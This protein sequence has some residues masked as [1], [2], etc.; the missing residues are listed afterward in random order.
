MSDE[1]SNNDGRNGERTPRGGWSGSWASIRDL[2]VLRAVISQ[3]GVTTAA[4]HLSISQPAVSRTLSQLEERSGRSF[5][6]RQGA[7]LVPTAEA[8]RLFAATDSVFE[9]LARIEEFRWLEPEKEQLSIVAAPTLGHCLLP[10]VLARF[11]H[12]N[13]NITIRLDIQTSVD[14]VS[15]VA[16]GQADIGIAEVPEGDW[17]V[18]KHP[19]RRSSLAVAMPK[20]HEWSKRSVI[21]ADELQSQPLI[22]LLKRN[23]FRTMLDRLLWR[24]GGLPNIVIET[25]DALSAVELVEQGLGLAVVNPFPVML[26]R[27]RSLHYAVLEPTMVYETCV[28]TNSSGPP[29]P[30]VSLLIEALQAV[31]APDTAL[32][33]A[34]R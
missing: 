24:E 13:P 8:M 20:T 18:R 12:D 7:Q 1:A 9:S 29:V 23:P 17:G 6:T 34:V 27:D 26:R 3:G 30:G 31:Q 14:V 11:A 25:S 28:I 32:S 33:K 19:F 4:R 16:S 5:F 15:T 2:E 22:V 10:Q 21:R